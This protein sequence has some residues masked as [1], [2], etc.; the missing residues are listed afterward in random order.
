MAEHF[1]EPGRHEVVE[2][3]V[4][5]GAQIEADSRDDV[6]MLENLEVVLRQHVDVAP[7]QAVHVKGS[8]AQTEHDDQDTW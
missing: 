4:D 5:G 1:S 3:G 6:N 8:P 2:D 7:H